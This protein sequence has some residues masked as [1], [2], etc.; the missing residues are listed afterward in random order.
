MS[1]Y[2]LFSVST[3]KETLLLSQNSACTYID[4]A[5]KLWNTF[6]KTLT[7][8]DIMTT[9]GSV[10]SSVKKL[11]LEAQQKHDKNEWSVLNYS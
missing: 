11:I 6:N 2:E 10:K 9:I 8:N 4:A 7:L 5:T 3:R 1:M